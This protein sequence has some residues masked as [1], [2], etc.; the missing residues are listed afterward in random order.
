MRRNSS[1]TNHIRLYS[2]GLRVKTAFLVLVITRGISYSN[3]S[4]PAAGDS[5][6]IS[7]E[8]FRCRLMPARPGGS[9]LE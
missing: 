8:L 9:S 4:P 5:Y 2:E 1:S 7:L 6:E 3:A